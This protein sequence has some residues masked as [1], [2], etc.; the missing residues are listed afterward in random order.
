MEA[1]GEPFHVCG[2]QGY[3]EVK[4]WPWTVHWERGQE[5]ALEVKETGGAWEVIRT[6]WGAPTS[7]EQPERSGKH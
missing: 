5:G 2:S 6:L 4:L 3:S 1:S 7:E